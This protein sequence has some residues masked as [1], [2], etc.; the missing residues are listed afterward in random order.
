ALDR[1]GIVQSVTIS[2]GGHR[3]Y[4]S[5]LVDEPDITPGRETQ[6][7]PGPQQRDG[8]PVGVDLGV[9]HLAALSTGETIDNPRHLRKARRRL[10]K[11]Q[12]AVSRKQ[13]PDRRTKRTPS[14]RW[15]KARARLARL[16]HEV[17]E[18][19]SAHLHSITKKLATGHTVIAIEDL[20]VAGMVGSARGNAD[21]PGRNVRAK[22]GLNRSILD[23]SPGEFRRQL[24]YKTSWYGS[25]L[26]V[27]DQWFPS[28]KTCSAC[29]A[30]KAKLSLSERVFICDGCGM[31]LDRDVNAA[32]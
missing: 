12:R 30:V 13:G 11:A 10:P 28:S 32:R 31:V 26:D 7:G 19:R 25:Q 23:A 9:K 21:E 5:V 8:G 17:A 2:Q 4:A 1:G 29:G 3:W 22:A 24:T 14:N 16:H 27:C 15:R 6:T 18:Q 20:N